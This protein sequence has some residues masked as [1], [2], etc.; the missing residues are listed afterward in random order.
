M[1][2]VLETYQE[3]M[4]KYKA[5]IEADG[6]PPDEMMSFQEMNYRICVLDTIRCMLRVCPVTTDM[7]VIAEHFKLVSCYMSSLLKEHK[8]LPSPDEARKNQVATAH[9]SLEH[10]IQDGNNFFMSFTAPNPYCY[11]ESI[12]KYCFTVLPIWVQYR[13]TFISL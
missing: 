6:L 10:V 1:A 12:S 7:Q 2:T 8:I 9:S 13:Q 3:Q 11:R 4:R 5:Q